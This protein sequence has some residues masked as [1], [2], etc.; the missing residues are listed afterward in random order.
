[1]VRKETALLSANG[2]MLVTVVG[3]EMKA[4]EVQ[5]LNA[6]TPILV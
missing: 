4:R 3:M 1:M 2:P 5:S 6:Y